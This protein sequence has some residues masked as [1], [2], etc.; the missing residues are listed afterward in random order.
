MWVLVL[1]YCV[2]AGAIATPISIP[3]GGLSCASSEQ[4]RPCTYAELGATWRTHCLCPGVGPTKNFTLF[5][6]HEPL[7]SPL[8]P[9]TEKLWWLVNGTSPGP[10]IVVDE[11]DWVVVTVVSAAYDS[12][13]L[14]HWHGQLQVRLN[15]ANASWDVARIV[16]ALFAG[17]N[18]I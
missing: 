6:T 5:V 3:V 18:T 7:P 11:G 1:V 16:V 10:A 12:P 17:L 9:D 4:K 13:T 2:L 8:L 15:H 14:I